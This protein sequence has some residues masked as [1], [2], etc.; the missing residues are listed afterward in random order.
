[1]TDSLDSILR[2]ADLPVQCTMHSLRV[3]A[4]L[5]ESRAG[6]I[7]DDIMKPEGWKTTSVAEYYIGSTTSTANT[8]KRRKAESDSADAD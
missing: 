3:G 5:R 1:M 4:S 2:N 6:R 7:V 8:A